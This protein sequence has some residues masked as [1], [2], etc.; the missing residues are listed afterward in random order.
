M[1]WLRAA[2]VAC[3]CLSA[4]VAAAATFDLP[5]LS[6]DSYAYQAALRRRFPAG[7][8]TQDRL[9]AEQA[10]HAAAAK[11]D[12]A[13]AAAAWERRIGAGQ[14]APD[15]WLAL[16]KA[17]MRRSPPDATHALDAAWQAYIRVPGGKRQIPALRVMVSALRAQHHALPEIDVLQAIVDRAPTDTAARAALAA[18]RQ[19]LGLLVKSV[20]T[21]PEAYPARACIG[22][23]ARPGGDNFHARDWVTLAPSLADAAVTQEGSQICISGLPLGATTR[24]SLRAGLPAIDGT[25]LKAAEV[26]PVAMPNRAPRLVFDNARFL[27]PR[28]AKPQLTLSSVNIS[29]VKLSLARISERNIVDFLNS[30]GPGTRIDFYTARQIRRSSGRVVWR[31]HARIPHFTANRLEN[32]T[33]PLPAALADAKPGLFALI[34]EPGDGTPGEPD[35]AVALQL[36]LRTDLAPTVWRGSD[37]LTVQV[38]GY[39]TARAKPG[40]KAALLAA[41]NDVLATATTDAAGV[42]RFPAP[43]LHGAHGQRPVELHLFGPHGDFTVLNLSAPA[44]DL[45]GRGV[46]G[47]PQPG[48]L[49]AFVWLDRGIYRPGETVHVMALLRDAAGKPMDV[50]VH[51]VIRRPGGQVF[52]DSVPPRQ[53]DDSIGVPVPL[54]GGA[55]AGIWQ[56]SI[57]ADPKAPPIGHASFRVEAFVPARLRVDL[58]KTTGPIVPGRALDLPVSVRFLYGAAGSGLTGSATLRLVEDETPFPAF[59]GYRFGLADEIF[60]PEQRD[61]AVPMTDAAG[62]AKLT[63]ALPSVPDTTH[64]LTARVQVGIN[65]P[66]GRAVYAEKQVKVRPAGPMIGIKPLFKGDAVDAN[67]T[68]GFRIIAVDPLGKRVAMQVQL[69]L[70][71]QSPDWRLVVRGGVARYETVWRDQPLTTKTLTIPAAKPLDLSENLGFG[72]YRLEVTQAGRGLAASSVVFYSGWAS[73]GNPN[74]PDPVSISAA[75]KAYAP[76]AMA[77]IHITP[78]FAGRA[79]I[80]VLTDRVIS[81]RDIAVPKGGTDIHVKVGAGWGPGAYVAV[82]MF[83]PGSTG[84]KGAVHPPRRAIGLAWIAVHDP[85]RVLAV[86]FQAKPQYRPRGNA[87]IPVQ[88]PPGSWVSLAAVDEGVLRLTGFASPD[89]V[90]HFLGRRTLGVDIRDG[91]GALIRPAQGPATLLQQGGGE[92]VG[93]ATPPNIPQQVVALFSPPRQAGADGI[94]RFPLALPDFNGQLRLMAVA[95]RGNRIGAASRDIY[96]RDKLVAEPLLPRFLAPGDSARLAVLMQNLQL[97]AGAD[98]VNLSVSGPLALAGPAS[99]TATLAPGA[100]AEPS[101]IL[102][103]TGVGTGTIRLKVTGPGGY[104]ITRTVRISVHSARPAETR[105]SYG[106]I[107]PNTT[108]RLTPDTKGLIPG[109]WEAT[110]SFGSAIRYDA[111]ALVRALA[112]YPLSCLEQSVSRGLPLAFLPNGSTAGSDRAGRLQLAV[113]SVLDRQRYDGGFGL[114]SANDPAEPWLSAYATEF[115]LRARAAGAAVPQQPLD[116]AFT[117]LRQQTAQQPDTPAARAAD[118]YA[119]YVL[120]L[121]G[122]P[123]AGAVRVLAE[124]LNRLPTPLARMQLAAALAHMNDAA[125]AGRIMSAVLDHP[126][127]GFW[128]AD[129]GSALRDRFATAVILK[130]SGLLPGRLD[131]LV[132]TLPGGNLSPRFLDT[133]EQAWGAAAAAVLGAGGPDVHV[134]FDGTALPPAPLINVALTGPVSIRNPTARPVWESMTVTGVPATTLPAAGHGMEISRQFFTMTGTPL[135]VMALHQNTVFVLL[136]SGRA[137]DGQNHRLMVLDGLPAGWE[138]A[139]TLRNGAPGMKWLGRLTAPAA[140][141]AADD[142]YQAALDVTGKRPAFRLAVLLRAVTPGSFD[143]PAAEVAD[144]YRPA[145]FARTGGSHVTV[146]PAAP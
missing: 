140:E 27:L 9:A 56:V 83:R 137:T 60:A 78:P 84:A 3:L 23:T 115:L 133:Q 108:A 144:M 99:L 35:G 19:A 143:E 95:W 100:R 6:G 24:V 135:S 20:H 54:S 50:P 111:A 39:A 105:V 124:H 47:R 126:A 12:W 107:V 68:A 69:R 5:G 63:I 74:R 92:N 40:V 58:G 94:V 142:R 4:A 72:R 55:Q 76:G 121:A 82:Q 52:Q 96:V 122:Q 91:W 101:T 109:S 132:A 141:P 36:I 25:T 89:P 114:W 42:V 61:L 64:A 59:A 130:Q 139:G 73:S 102:N 37:G 110:A 127:R 30:N 86:T 1:R 62:H 125:Q 77:R 70:V 33:L 29:A 65:D 129:Y 26:L 48:P 34:A 45:S 134:L 123:Q 38:R 53:A 28:E 21:E 51:V 104:R 116:A 113:A 112:A 118:A 31:G 71:R 8:T 117:F 80:L 14:A 146:L 32:T 7:A 119:L 131:R 18:R 98:D 93:S 81:L 79:S 85:A 75:H 138:V 67:T 13:G 145:L 97:P 106:K 10:A 22:F 43:L 103:A 66:A 136:L 44:F 46:S 11:G 15:Q 57:E 17:Q 88:V 41:N 16:A 90:G 120:A 2:V 128:Y 87:T 49:D